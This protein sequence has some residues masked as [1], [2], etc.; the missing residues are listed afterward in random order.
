M[1]SFDSSGQLVDQIA[2]HHGLLEIYAHIYTS[3]FLSAVSLASICLLYY[4]FRSSVFKYQSLFNGIFYTGLIGLGETLEHVSADPITGSMFHYLHLLAAPFA[5]IFYL[6]S[7]GEIFG[8]NSGE[9]RKVD[10]KKSI[11]SVIAV[12]FTAVALSRFSK[13]TWDARIEVPFVLIT[14]IPTLVLVREV[15]KKSKVISESTLMLASLRIIILGV[16]SLTISILAGRYGDIGRNAT[17]YVFFH[18]IQSISHVVTGTAIMMLVWTILQIKSMT[19][20]AE[21]AQRPI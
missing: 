12:V 3:M 19:I 2:G 7:I 4:Y 1:V 10:A 14:T 18:E 15:L 9:V 17:A 16:S 11:M 8:G 13:F 6:L 21:S 20:S 5:L